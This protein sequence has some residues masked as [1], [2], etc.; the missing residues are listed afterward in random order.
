MH[1][2]ACKDLRGMHA[3]T[4]KDLKGVH[5]QTYQ[6]ICIHKTPAA[7]EESCSRQTHM[8]TKS[9]YSQRVGATHRILKPFQHTSKLLARYSN[10]S[11]N[12]QHKYTH[13]HTYT[14]TYIHTLSASTG[15]CGPVLRQQRFRRPKSRRKRWWKQTAAAAATA[16]AFAKF[17][18]CCGAERLQYQSGPA[19]E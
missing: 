5:A 7:Q 9:A 6:R 17:S 19:Q 8:H 12:A 2:Q 18:E 13:I 15:R 11:A 10:A 4:Y 1:A 14:H 3:Q 16:R